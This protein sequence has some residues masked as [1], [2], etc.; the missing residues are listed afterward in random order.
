LTA[1]GVVPPS[2]R[3][4]ILVIVND[5]E[6]G[7]SGGS[8][9]VASTDVLAAELI[10]HET[11]HTF[12]FLA[13]EYTSQPP[14]CFDLFEPSEAN[15]TKQTIRDLIKWTAWIDFATPVPT[16]D[17]NPGIPGLYQGAKYC[18]TTLYRPTFNSK[19]RSLS[20]P[21]EQINTEQFIKRFY[22]FAR[23]IDSQLP[24]SSEI[25][26]TQGH[27]QEFHIVTPQPATHSL[28]ITWVLDGQQV[29]TGAVYTLLSGGL[30]Q[31]IHSLTA[32]VDD[33][34]PAVRIDP[35]SRLTQQTT[36]TIAVN[37]SLRRVRAQVTSQ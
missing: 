31:G 10:L 14:S 17:E 37:A 2:Q 15:A 27:S 3:D 23:P 33:P 22:D 26:L 16:N 19:M 28:D 35:Q 29:A 20:V 8:I 5:P 13:D 11:G 4:L 32:T 18:P 1:A 7:G 21:Y 9:A 12:A 25:S 30:S 24:A 6:Y 34:T 36:W